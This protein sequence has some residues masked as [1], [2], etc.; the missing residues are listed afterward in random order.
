MTRNWLMLIPAG[1]DKQAFK[2]HTHILEA[3]SIV[4]G[5]RTTITIV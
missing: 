5:S 2:G 1:R 3:V 4:M